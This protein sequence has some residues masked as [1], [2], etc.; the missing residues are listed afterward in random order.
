M[1]VMC[2]ENFI[3]YF[4]YFSWSV[5]AFIEKGYEMKM[6]VPKCWVGSDSVYWPPLGK[7][8]P[9]LS[10]HLANLTQP[11]TNTWLRYDLTKIL[12]G[13]GSKEVCK[14][15]MQAHVDSSCA[16]NNSTPTR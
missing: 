10:Y 1:C 14:Q 12:L 6:V 9:N 8:L 11:N 13:S 5:V 2:C 3:M 16:S 7:S 4:I 15:F